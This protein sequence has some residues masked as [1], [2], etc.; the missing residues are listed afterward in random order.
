MYPA[1]DAISG[2]WLHQ[3]GVTGVRVWNFGIEPMDRVEIF[4][5]NGKIQFSVFEENPLVLDNDLMK[6]KLSIANPKH[7]QMMHVADLKNHLFEENFSHPSTG[8]T[9]VNN[10]WLI[11]QIREP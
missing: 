9:A 5:N 8:E 11:D 10:S 4:G 1:K 6:V 3:G 2:C 7:V